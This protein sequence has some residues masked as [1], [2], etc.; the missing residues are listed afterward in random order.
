[1]SPLQRNGAWAFVAV[2]V[3]V[4]LVRGWLPPYDDAFFFVRFARN[5]FEH[6]GFAWNVADGPVYGNTS[7]LFQVLVAGVHGLVGPY[8]VAATRLLLAGCLVG[9]VWALR[10]SPPAVLLMASPV[11]LATV[12]SGMETAVAL[13]LGALFLA[14]LARPT[15]ARRGVVVAWA[16]LLT[17]A[18]PDAALLVVVTL[19]WDRR[20]PALAATLLCIGLGVIGLWWAYGTPVPLSFLTKS[21]IGSVYDETFLSLSQRA[22]QRHVA[23]FLWVVLP[24]LRWHPRLVPAALFVGYH[25]LG[26][27]DVMGLHGRFYAPVLPWIA[28]AAAARPAP[29]ADRRVW[30][31]LAV[32]AAVGVA[33]VGF[34]VVPVDRG[35]EI[36][37]ISPITY[38]AYAVAVAVVMAP[39]RSEGVVVPLAAAVVAAGVV[40]A[41]PRVPEAPQRDNVYAWRLDKQVTSFRGLRR[42]ARCLGTDAH[43]MHSEIGVPGMILRDGTVTDLGGLMS[44]PLA[45]GQATVGEVCQQQQPDAI[46]L[47]HR[48]YVRLNELLKD[49]G[50]LEG[51]A[52]VVRRS[53]SPLHVRRDRLRDYHCGERR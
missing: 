6:G 39:R 24:W 31:G 52:R 40:I 18:R 42:L 9:S 25:V 17:L 2:V 1:M 23:L 16:V 13:L 51:Y 37:R 38:A 15:G 50:C 27:V 28:M 26:N 3:A 10:A 43:V 47:P 48:N 36:G 20:W 14:E 7:Q 21:G 29:A 11:A 44:P 34:E 30:A 19:A 5:L 8:T 4:L 46:F 49:S 33:L 35:W 41:H 53:S 32:W 12:V 22:K 45:L